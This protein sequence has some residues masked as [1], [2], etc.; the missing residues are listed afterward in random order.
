MLVFKIAAVVLVILLNQVAPVVT[1]DA[2]AAPKGPPS[3]RAPSK[4]RKFSATKAFSEAKALFDQQKYNE[5]L[6]ILSD[7]LRKYPDHESAQLLM[8]KSFYRME[9]QPE[10]YNLFARM[11]PQYLDP[12][13]SYEYATTMYKAKQYPQ[14]LYSYKNVPKNHSLYDLANYYGALSAIKL[15]KFKV[16]EEMMERAVVLPD[17]LSKSKTQYL[18]HLTELRILREKQ[19]LAKQKKIERDKLRKARKKSSTTSAESSPAASVPTEYVHAGS[20]SISKS[21]GISALS[22]TQLYELHGYGKQ[23]AETRQTSF[24]FNQ[25]PLWSFGKSNRRTALGVQLALGASDVHTTGEE[26]RNFV[27]DTSRDILRI[28]TTTSRT[29]TK[30]GEVSLVP[31]VDIPAPNDLWVALGADVSF[32]Y[33]EFERSQRE[34]SQGGFLSIKGHWLETTLTGKVAFVEFIDSKN[35][36]VMNQVAFSSGASFTKW[37]DFAFILG[38]AVDNFDYLET[39]TDGP[40]TSV[41]LTAAVTKPFVNFVSGTLSGSFESQTNNVLHNLA[42]FAE[43]RADGQIMGIKAALGISPWPWLTVAASSEFQNAKW[44]VTSP[45]NAQEVFERNQSDV[46]QTNQASV[47]LNLNF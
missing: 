47:T 43:I 27:Y 33:T 36:P 12:E 46:L 13:T 2:L 38:L 45:E 1:S 19:L 22:K 11:N 40:D 18:K 3:K 7:I 41:R 31:F 23:K 15:R 21:A 4:N 14:A 10:A 26:Q 34:G 9:R 16:A 17:K 30:Y 28:Q 25:G 24:S 6:Q 44:T 42:S 32:V 39:L 20:M 29:T 8:A 37:S 5:C 35:D